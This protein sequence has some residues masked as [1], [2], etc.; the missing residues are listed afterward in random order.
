MRNSANCWGNEPVA[1]IPKMSC[2]A[3]RF[4]TTLPPRQYKQ[5]VGTVLALVNSPEPRDSQLLKGARDD[6]RRVDVG[7]CR[8]VYRAEGDN[9]LV[10]V[11]GKRVDSDTYG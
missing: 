3:G 9:L 7:E 5:V 8:I 10:L 6:N 2:Q 1:L 4:I 11:A